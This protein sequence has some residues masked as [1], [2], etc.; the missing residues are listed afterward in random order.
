MF[1][2]T[3]QHQ[4]PDGNFVVEVSSGGIDYCNPDALTA[5]YAGEFKEFADPRIAV[6]TAIEIVRA[7]R[8]DSG[9]HISIGVGSTHGMTMPF[10]SGT[11]KEARAWAKELW[12]KMPK[13]PHCSEPMP[14]DKREFWCANDW[15]GLEY[16][17]EQCANRA[18]EFEQE[19]M[20]EFESEEVN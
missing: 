6:E 12:E 13:C 8:K 11:F 9:K 5:K 18:L 19:Q 15:D 7:W 10:D 17:S 2:V 16:C 14:D 3:R 1:T 20:A 4:W